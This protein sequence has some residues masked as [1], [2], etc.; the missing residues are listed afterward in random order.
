MRIKYFR[1]P[2][3]RLKWLVSEEKSR[4]LSLTRKFRS[5]KGCNLAWFSIDILPLILRFYHFEHQYL[6]AF[7]FKERIPRVKDFFKFKLHWE[8][9]LWVFTCFILS[10]H[11]ILSFSNLLYFWNELCRTEK[12]KKKFKTNQYHLV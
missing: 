12:K 10:L 3:S 2:L 11:K 4:L 9:I 1:E 6:E 5:L 7:F 8:K